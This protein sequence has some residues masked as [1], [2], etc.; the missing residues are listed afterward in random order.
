[1]DKA[2][3]L[4]GLIAGAFEGRPRDFKVNGL[5]GAFSMDFTTDD[6]YYSPEIYQI[7]GLPEGPEN[8]KP[9]LA[10]SMC[11]PDSVK[12]FEDSVA[13]ARFHGR[14]FDM[15]LNIRHGSGCVAKVRITGA[16]RFRDGFPWMLIGTLS[17]LGGNRAAARLT[18]GRGG[19]G[20]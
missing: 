17:S 13:A 10:S 1:M 19:V 12:M 18:V 11:M 8:R 6:L 15:D 20:K 4:A 3:Q 14:G 5:V 16:V 7:F 9:G 2:A